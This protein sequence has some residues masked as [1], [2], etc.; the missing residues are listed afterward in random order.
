M[1]E[2]ASPTR[3]DRGVVGLFVVRI[4]EA[5]GFLVFAALGVMVI[6]GAVC[7]VSRPELSRLVV[8]E[9]SAIAGLQ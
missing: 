8:A 3:G 6:E 1:N 7:S 9:V 5:E 4:Q 2:N